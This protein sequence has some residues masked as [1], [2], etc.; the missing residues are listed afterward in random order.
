MKIRDEYGEG[1]QIAGAV[2]VADPRT[3]PCAYA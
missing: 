3:V 2:A 1:E